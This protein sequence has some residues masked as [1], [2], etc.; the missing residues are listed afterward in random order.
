M[1]LLHCVNEQ[2]HVQ[3]DVMMMMVVFQV[4]VD[5]IDMG[6]VFEF[7]CQRWFALDEDDGQISRELILNVGPRDASPGM[8]HQLSELCLAVCFMMTAGLHVTCDVDVQKVKQHFHPGNFF[9][10]L[11]NLLRGTGLRP[12]HSGLSHVMLSCIIFSQGAR[13]FLCV[14]VFNNGVHC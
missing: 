11:K 1:V 2:P 3:C 4:I 14:V 10:K 6:T 8:W 13:F 5:D 9:L 12:S 7:P